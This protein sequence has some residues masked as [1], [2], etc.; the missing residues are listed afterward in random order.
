MP[1]GGDFPLIS[2][3]VKSVLLEKQLL[4]YLS[5]FASFH[6][7]HIVRKLYFGRIAFWV[8]IAFLLMLSGCSKSSEIKVGLIALPATVARG[9]SVVVQLVSNRQL[10]K[11]AP[12]VSVEPGDGVLYSEFQRVSD[13]LVSFRLVVDNMAPVGKRIVSLKLGNTVGNCELMVIDKVDV[14]DTDVTATDDVQVVDTASA[15]SPA[16]DS[17]TS[18]AQPQVE[19]RGGT[20]MT[21]ETKELSLFGVNTH[22]SNQSVVS[23][24]DGSGLTVVSVNYMGTTLT[25]GEQLSFLLAADPRATI[26]N[27]IGTVQSPVG[28]ELE[29]AYFSIEVVPAPTLRVQ[30]SSGYPEETLVVALQ[31]MRTHFQGEAP[32]TLVLVEPANQGVSINLDA[33]NSETEMTATVYISESAA[34][35]EYR[36]TA[37]TPL[38]FEGTETVSATFTV[39]GDNGDTSGPSVDT[40]TAVVD[41]CNDFTVSP[42]VISVGSFDR[43]LQL[44]ASADVNWISYDKA[45]SLV[46]ENAHL[47]LGELSQTP[48]EKCYVS[49]SH[50]ISC[51]LNVGLSATPGEYE[52]HVTSGGVTTCGTLT[53]IGDDIA[54]IEIPTEYLPTYNMYTGTLDAATNASDFYGFSADAGTTAVFHAYS[55]NR[56]TMDPILRLIN[57]SGDSWVTFD[58]DETPL[59]IDARMVFHFAESGDCYL[60]VG[61]KLSDNEGDYQLYTYL[62]THGNVTFEDAAAN[63]SFETAQTIAAPMGAVVHAT[64]SSSEDVDYYFFETTG[65]ST[66][67]VVARR[68]D[69]RDDGFADTRITLY[70]TDQL[71]LDAG[72]SWYEIPSTADPRLFVATAGSYYLKVEAEENTSGFYALNIRPFLVINELDNTA[73]N[74][75]PWVE[76]QGD[77]NLDLTGYELCTFDGDGNEIDSSVPCADLSGFTTDADGYVAIYASDFISSTLML[78]EGPGAVSLLYQGTVMDKVQYGVVGSNTLAEG[79]PA[80]VGSQRAI[81]R[82]AGVD[83]NNNKLDFIYMATPSPGMPNDRTYQSAIPLYGEPAN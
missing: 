21:G 63:D 73:N 24:P 71:E 1:F 8:F 36:I 79:S 60:E 16:V 66:I 56:T 26:G 51:A 67:Q 33:V 28:A 12:K 80:E 72:S 23:F 58:D 68:L 44:D 65:P 57:A 20:I 4:Y 19:L 7:T 27:L 43:I 11:G 50:D 77:Y 49:T 75:D 45:I 83:S 9:D 34:P 39:N 17:Q 42:G 41:H 55:L 38:E 59:G 31:G 18:L 54:K 13:T 3:V 25:D 6:F 40:D 76:L 2:V 5:L 29:T 53:V 47:Y 35:G 61:P 15:T 22:F 74:A 32:A 10:D 62:L 64:M 82:G 14:A 37:S 30:P 81:G 69:L 52:I 48:E 46:G 70:D 78:P